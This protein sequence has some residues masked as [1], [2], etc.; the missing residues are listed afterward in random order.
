MI[1]NRKAKLKFSSSSQAKWNITNSKQHVQL[2]HSDETLY[3]LI[4]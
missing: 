4:I 1:I 3:I 2:W